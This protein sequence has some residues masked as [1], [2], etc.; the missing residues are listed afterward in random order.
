MTKPAPYPPKTAE[1]KLA[2]D[3]LNALIDPKLVFL[4]IK[5]ISAQI[6]LVQGIGLGM[7][8]ISSKNQ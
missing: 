2:I 3:T 5:K 7:V 6:H 4:D 8:T 1:E